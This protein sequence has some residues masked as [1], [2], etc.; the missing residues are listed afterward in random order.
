LTRPAELCQKKVEDLSYAVRLRRLLG[1]FAPNV[2]QLS[3]SSNERFQSSADPELGHNTPERK[4]QGGFLS[5][6]GLK[7]QWK[8]RDGVA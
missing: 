2:A 7:Q 5:R 4:T 1:D 8:R 6:K 3:T